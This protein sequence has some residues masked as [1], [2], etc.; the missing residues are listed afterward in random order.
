MQQLGCEARRGDDGVINYRLTGNRGRLGD[1]VRDLRH[2]IFIP[3]I[4]G[5]GLDEMSADEV[6][7]AISEN[8]V[9][10]METDSR[11]KLNDCLSG[12]YGS[13]TKPSYL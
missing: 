6:A 10:G 7:A 3:M 11:R 13:Q 1:H 4:G 5:E 9:M 12:L 8:L 2:R